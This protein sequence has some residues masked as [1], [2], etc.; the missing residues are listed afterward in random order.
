MATLYVTSSA[1]SGDGTFRDC[2][3]R[4]VDGDA[5]T[6]R[7]FPFECVLS[8]PI[9]IASAVTINGLSICG[10]AGSQM[11]LQLRANITFN[12]CVFAGLYKQSSG[13][14]LWAYAASTGATFNRC[15][16]FNNYSE[17]NAGAVYVASGVDVNF[18]DCL[19]FN[20]AASN[21]AL[22]FNDATM[23]GVI[24][25]CTIYDNCGGDINKSGIKSAC[26]NCLL[27]DTASSAFANPVGNTDKDSWASVNE[28]EYSYYLAA[29]IAGTATARKD[30]YGNA[31]TNTS[32]G[33]IDYVLADYFMYSGEYFSDPQYNVLVAE[34]DLTNKTVAVFGRQTLYVD[35]VDVPLAYRPTFRLI[36]GIFENEVVNGM[37]EFGENETPEKGYIC[38]N[39]IIPDRGAL[40]SLDYAQVVGTLTQGENTTINCDFRRAAPISF[41]ATFNGDVATFTLVKTN[42][43]PV[44]IYRGTGNDKV[45]LGEDL[46]GAVISDTTQAIDFTC[47]DGTEQ[48]I[49]STT[50]TYYYKGGES[51][52]FTNPSDW[53]VDEDKQIACVDAPTIA[54]CTFIATE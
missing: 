18:Y 49:A 21:A 22:Y 41:D 26:V 50:R 35:Q 45:Y 13:G 42:A 1:D 16:L 10:G 2:V 29:N 9:S 4:A 34:P 11:S 40:N 24:E 47:D 14:P 44:S 6:A 51:G 12:D 43:F 7:T 32:K 17:G 27:A 46:A 25:N 3:E 53:A 31:R 8:Q 15:R 48:L 19:I 33:A 5:I 54:G 39:F 20:N 28:G 36:N 52:S 23:S 37:I 30:V 38:A